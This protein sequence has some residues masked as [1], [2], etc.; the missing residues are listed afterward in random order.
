MRI[1]KYMQEDIEYNEYRQQLLQTMEERDRMTMKQYRADII[2]TILALVC[3]IGS[4]VLFY[5]FL[6]KKVGEMVDTQ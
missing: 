1:I 4:A 2:R 5:I 6:N 3:I